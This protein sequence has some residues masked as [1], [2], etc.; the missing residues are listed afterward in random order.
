MSFFLSGDQLRKSDRIILFHQ[1]RILSRQDSVYWQLTEL[2]AWRHTL[3]N[4]HLIQHADERFLAADA[5]ANLGYELEAEESSLR[6]LLFSGNEDLLGTA[7]KANQVLDWYRSHQ[8]C[9]H[10]GTATSPHPSERAVI[11]TVCEKHYFP[12]INPCIIVLITRGDRVLL[13]SH[14][15]SKGQFYSCLAGFIE[16]GESAEDTVHREIMEEVGIRVGNI[17]YVK[18]QSWPFPSQLMLG[19]YADYES[20]DIVPE[21]AEIAHADWFDIN[22]LP[23][24]PA[25]EISVAGELIAGYTASRLGDNA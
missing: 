2:W 10:C 19:F 8:Y 3:G 17:R 21:E 22:E 6:S 5:P 7:G 4:I 11:C 23:P 24:H 16:I 13:A 18:S 1:G 25:A 20:G 12:R 14:Q 9:G 15:R